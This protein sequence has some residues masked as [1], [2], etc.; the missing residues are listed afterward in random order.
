M[1]E[2]KQMVRIVNTDIAGGKQVSHALT[3]ITGV[4]FPLS[5]AVCVVLNI[6]KQQKLGFLQDNQIKRIEQAIRNPLQFNIPPHLLNRRRD[7]ETGKDLHI[8]TSDLRLAKESDIK[9]FKKIKSYKGIRHALNLTVRGQRTR[10]NFR[11]GKSIGVSKK[12]K[13]GRK[14]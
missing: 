4:G 14:G 11:R 1:A 12:K 10:S 8:T 6:D 7:P 2:M 5:E 13:Q 9:M 3:Q